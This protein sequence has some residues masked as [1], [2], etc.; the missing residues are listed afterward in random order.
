[1]YKTAEKR[2]RINSLFSLAVIGEEI[3]EQGISS[4]SNK[5]QQG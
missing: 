5:L 2:K 4:Y 3:T 1:M